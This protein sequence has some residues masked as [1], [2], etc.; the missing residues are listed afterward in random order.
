MGE[1]TL[2]ATGGSGITRYV[3]LSD[4]VKPTGP[5]WPSPFAS[6]LV[7]LSAGLSATVG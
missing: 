7:E 6:G 4:A 5:S 1:V 3:E 2:P